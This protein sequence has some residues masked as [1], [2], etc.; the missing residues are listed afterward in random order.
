VCTSI[1]TSLLP[2]YFPAHDPG[3]EDGGHGVRAIRPWSG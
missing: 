3:V 1:A 2:E